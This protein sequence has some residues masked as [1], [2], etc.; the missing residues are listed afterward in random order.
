MMHSVRHVM[1]TNVRLLRSSASHTAWIGMC[2][3]L[4]AVVCATLASAFLH[5]GE[6]TLASIQTAQS[7]LAMWVLDVMP[8]AFAIWGQYVSNVV[9]HQ[10]G[11]LVLDQTE[12][13]RSETAAL[14]MQM[15]RRSVVDE[16][17]GI[18]N[19]TMFLDRLE[20]AV[21]S[22]ATSGKQVGLYTLDMRRFSEVNE[23]LGHHHG[24]RLLKRVATRLDN[25]VRAPT[26]LA[27][28]RG[29]EF[30]F[31]LPDLQ[32]LETL[33]ELNR[34]IQ[35]ALATPF[36]IE[37]LSIEL[38]T[39]AAA[40]VFPLHAEDADL[41]L[42]KADIALHEA[43]RRGRDYLVY[44]PSFDHHSPVRLTLMGELRRAIRQQ[45]MRLYLQPIVD[46]DARK[47]V[48]CEMLVRWQ[49]QK[50]GLIPPNEFIP[51]AEQS[52]A[53]IEL[54]HWVLNQAM[55]YGVQLRKLG[56]QSWVS[57]NV[58]ARV[59][60]DPDFVDQLSGMLASHRLPAEALLLEITEDTL[61]A[62]QQRV[63]AICDEIGQLGVGLAID[64]FGTG[65]S[66]LAYLKR[67][68]V[69]EIKIDRS[70]IADMHRS[71]NDE[72]IVKA[73]IDLGH[74]LGMQ[75]I[76]EGI[77]TEAQQ[78]TLKAMNIDA[79]QGYW[80]GRPMPFEAFLDWLRDHAII[81]A[82]PGAE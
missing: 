59:I 82:P 44:D 7:N 47:L 17:T 75:V 25:I 5:S 81:S 4:T 37:G 39:A 11:A 80:I 56:L 62:E 71:N 19:R 79:M 60:L 67:L 52:G 22:A 53:I 29:N 66:Q 73:A 72:V 8:F 38:Q 3:G 9:A 28:I 69:R 2:I 26:T 12:E 45:D 24:D 68:P 33:S 70:F 49:H 31:I 74:T 30:G 14:K 15:R 16:V 78:Q 27:R 13:L 18:T 50:M 46:A 64:D 23:T 54:S 55:A 10:A 41:L 36:S 21:A 65:Y 61:M 57:A 20:Q 1:M 43:K 34:S 35:T 40:A 76:A 48:G 6:V 51:L 58:S 63:T 42:Q 77:E 32:D